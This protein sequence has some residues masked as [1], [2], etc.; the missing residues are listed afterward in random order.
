MNITFLLI[1]G[2]WLSF[3]F[4]FKNVFD[5][6]TK[7]Q[8]KYIWTVLIICLFG[9]SAILFEALNPALFPHYSFLEFPLYF[10]LPVLMLNLTQGNS[11]NQ[12]ELKSYGYLHLLPSLLCFV[13]LLPVYAMDGAP[14]LEMA[15]DPL[16][17]FSFLKWLMVLQ[18]GCYWLLQLHSLDL[19]HK[20]INWSDSRWRLTLGLGF[21][22]FLL[23][24]GRLVSDYRLLIEALALGG[25]SVFVWFYKKEK[26]EVKSSPTLSGEQEIVELIEQAMVEKKIYLRGDLNLPKLAEAL[27]LSTHKV[28]HAI[29][30]AMATGYSDYVNKYRV[31]EV[32]RLLRNNT[33]EQYTLEAISRMAGFRSL[34]TFNVAF[35]KQ[36]GLTPKQFKV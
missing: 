20:K 17:I 27:Q 21:F 11:R 10:V 35:K 31:E 33:H 34:T 1:L 2:L 3:V 14:K 19:F 15:I 5:V 18:A 7:G 25:L 12:F 8:R 13:I 23:L 4:F 24:T 16:F 6:K 36:T 26:F 30:S 9:V 29:N 22:F 32:I 28:S